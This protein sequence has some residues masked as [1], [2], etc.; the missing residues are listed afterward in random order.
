MVRRLAAAVALLLSP[1]AVAQ[2]PGAPVP[3]YPGAVPHSFE[4]EPLPPPAIPPT[5]A[6]AP[7]QPQTPSPEA[8]APP[9]IAPTPAAGAPAE[10][11]FCQQAVSVQL[12]DPDSVAPRYR[13]FLGM[14]ADTSWT[15][16]L[17]AALVVD[18]IKPDGTASVVYVFGPMGPSAGG[19]AGTL[20]GTGI[21]RDGELQFQNSDGSQFAFRRFYGDLQGHLTTPQGQNYDADFKK[22]P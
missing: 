4:Q 2:Q 15:P 1:A 10:R 21:I 9:A 11:V 14:W 5:A 17:C 8:P 3:L 22:Q 7:Q 18:N 6:P 20:H 16:Q 19:P 13:P 12:A